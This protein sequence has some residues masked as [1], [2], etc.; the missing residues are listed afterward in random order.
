MLSGHKVGSEAGRDRDRKKR[1]TDSCAEVCSTAKSG[2]GLSVGQRCVCCLCKRTRR[3]IKLIFKQMAHHRS[4]GIHTLK[5]YIA[6]P[7]NNLWGVKE[8]PSFFAFLKMVFSGN[9]LLHLNQIEWCRAKTNNYQQET[10]ADTE[11]KL[12][13]VDI[14]NITKIL[15]A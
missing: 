12:K 1:T 7:V 14:H 5:R 8:V 4:V 3:H 9:S 6:R 15:H 2:C 13:R 11:L 10:A